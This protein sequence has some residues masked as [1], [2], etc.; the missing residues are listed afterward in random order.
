M[1]DAIKAV[2]EKTLE[3]VDTYLGKLGDKNPPSIVEVIQGAGVVADE[4]EITESPVQTDEIIA[5]EL[6]PE[7]STDGKTLKKKKKPQ[8]R[9]P[10]SPST[11]VVSDIHLYFQSN[12]IS[13]LNSTSISTY[14]F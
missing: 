14:K 8:Q 1:L 9:P 7:S 2:N 10:V 12:S 4:M 11:Q 5:K 3:L 6:T 13:Q